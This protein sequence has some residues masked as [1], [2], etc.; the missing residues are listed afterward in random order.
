MPA[1]THM[2]TLGCEEG[3]GT[4]SCLVHGSAAAMVYTAVHGSCYHQRPR[5]YAAAQSWPR[6]SYDTMENMVEFIISCR[7]DKVGI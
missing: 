4:V 3:T 7:F 1:Q 6:H 2:P 5:G